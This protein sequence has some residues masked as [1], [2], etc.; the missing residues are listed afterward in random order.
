[1]NIEELSTYN[2]LKIIRLYLEEG[3]GNI[4]K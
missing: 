4:W 3:F 1:M 2:Q